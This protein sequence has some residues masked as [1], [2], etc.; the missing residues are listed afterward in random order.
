MLL[1]RTAG[2]A[3]I[4]LRLSEIGMGKALVRDLWEHRDIG[5]YGEIISPV[6]PHGV[7]LYRIYR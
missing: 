5:V 1:N 6:E 3:D 2:K 4:T 7:K